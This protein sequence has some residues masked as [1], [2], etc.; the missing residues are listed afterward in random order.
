MVKLIFVLF[1]PRTLPDVNV[2]LKV[3]NIP[4]NKVKS[5]KFLRLFID[6]H[7]SWDIHGIS[8]ANRVSVA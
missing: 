8:I 4:I 6:E 2:D 5:T 1:R 3:N 7:F